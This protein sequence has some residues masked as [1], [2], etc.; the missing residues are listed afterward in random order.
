MT[1]QHPATPTGH[2]SRHSQAIHIKTARTRLLHPALSTARSRP[3]PL[4]EAGPTADRQ[5]PDK[6][7]HLVT[8]PDRLQEISRR[9]QD[10]IDPPLPAHVTAQYPPLP[11]A[12]RRLPASLLKIIVL[13]A[14]ILHLI[15]AAIVIGL[16]GFPHSLDLFDTPD[17]SDGAAPPAAALPVHRTASVTTPDPPN[18]PAALPT[19]PSTSRPSPITTHR[20]HKTHTARPVRTAPAMPSKAVASRPTPA[21]SHKATPSPTTPQPN[22]ETTAPTPPA[23]QPAHTPP[24]QTRQPPGQTRQPPGQTRDQPPPGQTQQ[25]PGQNNGK[26]HDAAQE[27]SDNPRH[28]HDTPAG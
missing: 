20:P 2:D 8:G 1:P 27:A 7:R 5:Q 24:G 10:G 25:P 15:L 11:P 12:R 14:G 19:S 4:G 13:F 16:P 28:G 17:G 26:T 21:A 22:P 9:G 18:R 23:Q 3:L 6:H